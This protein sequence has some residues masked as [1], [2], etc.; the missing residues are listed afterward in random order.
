MY[1]ESKIDLFCESVMIWATTG[2]IC[3][4]SYFAMRHCVFHILATLGCRWLPFIH[5]A[6]KQLKPYDPH[7]R[8]QFT[9]V[10]RLSVGVRP[11]LLFIAP[12]AATF[13][14]MSTIDFPSLVSTD[15]LIL[16]DSSANLA[17]Y[18]KII[19]TVL[20]TLTALLLTVT[21]LTIQVKTSNLAGPDIL[22]NAVIRKHGFL[23]VAAFLLGTVLSALVGILMSNRFSFR[24]LNDYTLITGVLSSGSLLVLLNLLRSTMQTLGSS[25]LGQLLPPELVSSLRISFRSALRQGLF[26]KHFSEGLA[27][28]GFARLYATEKLENHPTEYKLKRFGKIV[29]VDPASLKRISHILRLTPIPHERNTSQLL[30]YRPEDNTPYV[31]VQPNGTVR[32]ENLLALLTKEQSGDKQIAKLI[33]TAFIIQKDPRSDL[34]W[35]QIRQLIFSSIAKQE[36]TTVKAVANALENI[37][38]DYLGTQ[39]VIAGQG[40][41]LLEDFIGE[42][43]YGFKPP[44]PSNLR[45][46]ELVTYATRNHSDDCLDELLNCINKLAQTAFGKKNEKYFRDW[47]FDFYWAYHSFGPN[48]KDLKAHIAPNITDRIRWLGDFLHMYVYPQAQSVERVRQVSPYAITYLSLCLHMLKTSSERYDQTTFDSVMEH[49]AQFF[50]DETEDKMITFDIRRH[51]RLGGGS[52]AVSKQNNNEQ[53]QGL[54]VAYKELYDY[55]NLVWVIIG[56]WLMHKV[57]SKELQAKKSVPFVEKL[58]DSAPDFHSLLELYAMAGM[59]DMTNN[60]L[61]FDRWDWPPYPKGRSG[62]DFGKWIKP[63]YQFLLLKKAAAGIQETVNL[64][65]VRQTEMADHESL[66]RLLG[67]IAGEGYHLPDEY[68]GR[69]WSLEPNNLEAAKNQ[70]NT[71]L[72]S[73]ASEQDSTPRDKADSASAPK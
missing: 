10:E 69:T 66:K 22:L 56:A 24:S 44:H 13:A 35:Q 54:L 26:E 47:M 18:L 12:L 1:E 52:S 68:Q 20:A 16:V 41:L 72:N 3:E 71:L 6:E 32:E 4:D 57:K 19:A 55:K 45:F 21:A 37:L 65:A 33:G 15:P 25:E 29:A 9:P 2:R 51:S 46:S 8:P 27:D 34:D 7:L 62:T 58:I 39:L 11:W 67:E 49:V 23:P 5:E 40:N 38:A 60:A 70:L 43:V 17:S 61:A 28:L 64:E 53:E 30:L 31:T 36:S 73:W 48:T 50:K 63:F 42:I 14:L 59:A